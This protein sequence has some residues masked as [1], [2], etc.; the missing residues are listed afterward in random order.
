MFSWNIYS[1]NNQEKSSYLNNIKKW[2]ENPIYDVLTDQIEFVWT[3]NPNVSSYDCKRNLSSEIDSD[4][5]VFMNEISRQTNNSIKCIYFKWID[6]LDMKLN[7]NIC[8]DES[9]HNCSN[10]SKDWKSFFLFSA[11]TSK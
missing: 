2:A 1:N 7:R 10:T 11:K 4:Y 8:F 6:F 5:S 9:Q 3:Y